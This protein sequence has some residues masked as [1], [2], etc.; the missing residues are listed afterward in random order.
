MTAPIH[1]R[2]ILEMS[3]ISKRFD[4]T[5]ALEDVSLQLFPGEIHALLGENGAGKSTL[6]KVFSG[7]HC[8][9][10]GEILLDGRS[11]LVAAVE[12]VEVERA[13]TVL[14]ER[15]RDRRA[16]GRPEG[17]PVVVLPELLR[18]ARKRV[19]STR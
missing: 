3:D 10:E 13:A 6:M 15:P 4:M 12:V 5:Q 7:V 18:E 17:D 1:G 11:P 19:P 9:Y 16:L 2:P 8:D 14:P